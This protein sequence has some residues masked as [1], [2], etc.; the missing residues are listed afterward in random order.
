[1]TAGEMSFVALGG[2]CPTSHRDD[3]LESLLKRR[4]IRI[5]KGIRP[6]STVAMISFE[7]VTPT[8]KGGRRD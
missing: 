6:R 7:L 4:A 1:M 3:A 2:H 8:P 5:V